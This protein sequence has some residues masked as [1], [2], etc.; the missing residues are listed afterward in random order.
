MSRW[1]WVILLAVGLAL[2]AGTLWNGF[3]WDDLLTAVP[4]RPLG[5][6]L[7]QRT[8]MYYRPLVMLSF[9][10]DR[11]VWGDLPAGFHLTNLLLHVAAAGLL[12]TLA[13]AVGLGAGASLAAALVFL[14]HPVQS[15]AVTYVSGRTDV[16]CALFALLGFLAWRRARGPFDA[17]AVAATRGSRAGRRARRERPFAPTRM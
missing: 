8:G 16:L 1:R 14:A 7:T 6:V 13:A 4:S 9:A 11:A 12:A 5:E 3:V 10:L 15:E 17:W 2:Y